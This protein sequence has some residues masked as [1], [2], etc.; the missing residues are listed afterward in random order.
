ML[1]FAEKQNRMGGGHEREGK[2]TLLEDSYPSPE[3]DVTF[4]LRGKGE[5]GAMGSVREALGRA[6]SSKKTEWKKGCAHD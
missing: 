4:E 5:M 1:C 6:K 3:D 2:G